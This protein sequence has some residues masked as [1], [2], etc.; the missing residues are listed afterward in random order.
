MARK[1]QVPKFPG[2]LAE[3]IYEPT[4]SGGLLGMG[5]SEEEWKKRVITKITAKLF[6]FMDHYRIDY[7]DP[8]AWRNLSFNLA[9]DFVP[10]FTIE[11]LPPPKPGRRKTWQA[12]Q[13][14][15]LLR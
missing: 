10:G 5:I 12:G 8:Q 13:G 2:E 6:R 1:R 15:E 14:E 3:P 7:T 11:T 9:L 4:H